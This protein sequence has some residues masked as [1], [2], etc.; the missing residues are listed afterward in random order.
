MELGIANILPAD[1]KIILSLW[2]KHTR[3]EDELQI[4]QDVFTRL[5]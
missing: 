3:E 5:Q 1:K 2:S 4:L